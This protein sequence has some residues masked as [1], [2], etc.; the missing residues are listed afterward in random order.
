MP[1]PLF[2]D[3]LCVKQSVFL[4]LLF[5]ILSHPW[6]SPTFS[7]TRSTLYLTST[8]IN[9]WSSWTGPDSKL[10][11]NERNYIQPQVCFIHNSAFSIRYD[12]QRPSKVGSLIDFFYSFYCNWH[13]GQYTITW[14]LVAIMYPMTNQRLNWG[15]GLPAWNQDQC[16]FY[17][18]VIGEDTP[19]LQSV[20]LLTQV[21]FYHH[22]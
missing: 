4:L 9:G 10:L 3:N 6:E 21:Y 11:G 22:V 7:E 19:L 2:T 5:V 17:D 18:S 15:P 14:I 12:N 13:Y 20:K 16:S 8:N 1:H